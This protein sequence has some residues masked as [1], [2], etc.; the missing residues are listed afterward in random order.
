MHRGGEIISVL[1][2]GRFTA[3]V[4]DHRIGIFQPPARIN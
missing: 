3:N 2:I 1:L 4:S